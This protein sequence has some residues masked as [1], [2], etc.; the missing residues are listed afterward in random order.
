MLKMRRKQLY[1][2]SVALRLAYTDP[3]RVLSETLNGE[4]AED[5]TL[6]LH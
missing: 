4:P 2:R 1:L 5:G 6:F 3:F